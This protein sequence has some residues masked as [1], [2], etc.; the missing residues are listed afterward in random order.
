MLD[1]QLMNRK[2]CKQNTKQFEMQKNLVTFCSWVFHVGFSSKKHLPNLQITK[3]ILGKKPKKYMMGLT[4]LLS[5]T[6]FAELMNKYC[7]L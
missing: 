6:I 3:Y 2:L 7:K 4:F 1:M 5:Q